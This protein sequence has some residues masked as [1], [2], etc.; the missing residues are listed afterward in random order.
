MKTVQNLFLL[1]AMVATM[2]CQNDQKDSADNS[3]RTLYEQAL[4]ALDADSVRTGEQLLHSAIRQATAENDLHTLY[5]AQL[6]LAESLAWGNTEA[7]LSTAKQA[8]ET[9]ERYPDSERNHI[10]LLDYIGTYASQLAYNTDGS[11]DEALAYTR[12][13][14][15]LAEASRDN[16]GTELICQTLTSL[17]NIHWAM[18]DFD[19]AR[20]CARLAE[21]CSPAELLLG[22]QQVLAR[23]LFSCDSLAEAEAVY[24]AMQP[25]DDL[26]AAYIVQSNLAKLALRRNDTEGAE[27]AIDE[28]FSHAEEL[29]F[30]ALN[31][32]DD[33]YQTALQEQAENDR[34]R[35]RTALQRRTLLGGIAFILLL[36]LT[37]LYVVRERLRASEQRRLSEAK[38]HEQQVRLQEQQINA[39]REQL[40]QRDSTVQFLKDFILQRSEVIR[41][42]GTSADR[43]VALSTREWTEV[44]RTLDTID[45]DRFAC[46]RQRFPA[47]KAEDIQLCILTRLNLSNRAIGNIYG[48]SISAVQ[49]RKL[50]LKKEG[51]GEDDP[52]TTL[53]QVLD[54][55]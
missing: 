2:A 18:E 36:A 14:H 28:A 16:L 35:Y 52:E 6:R 32:K 29:Y 8:L 50:K 26:Q 11:F 5:L 10:I 24:R 3:A 17:A 54:R 44:E 1:L 21:A 42:L 33:Y 31:Q 39:Q 47:L 55:V 43:H 23:C 45:C 38:L 40:R 12:R 27:E 48:I 41:K 7:A 9:Y 34:L 20:R 30:K 53:E 49:H 13:A 25:G 46:L 19:E 22:T 4:E 37:A 15:A 51:F